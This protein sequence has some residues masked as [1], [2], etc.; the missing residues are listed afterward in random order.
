MGWTSG[1]FSEFKLF[2]EKTAVLFLHLPVDTRTHLMTVTVCACWQKIIFTCSGEPWVLDCRHVV[3]IIHLCICMSEMCDRET[4]WV[5]MWGC[6]CMCTSKSE[7]VRGSVW[8]PLR[9]RP[10]RLC[11]GT[12]GHNIPG[13]V[14][15]D[16]LGP[17]THIHT[18]TKSH[19]YIHTSKIG[20]QSENYVLLSM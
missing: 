12:Q 16:Q 20:K 2:T 19:A 4:A 17:S 13:G 10:K 14:H 5:R 6:V 18:H 9:C 7:S 11:P 1:N 8:I 3:C 15:R